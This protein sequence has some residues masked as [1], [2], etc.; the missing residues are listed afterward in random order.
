MAEIIY[1]SGLKSGVIGFKAVNSIVRPANTTAYAV[2]DLINDTAATT[3]LQFD[4]GTENANATLEINHVTL[5]SDYISAA[6]KL[7]AAL[8][9]FNASTIN[10]AGAVSQVTD[11]AAFNPSWAQIIAKMEGMVESMADVGTLGTSAYTIADESTTIVKL[12]SNGKIWVAITANNAYT[13]ASG[14]NMRLTIKGY[15]LG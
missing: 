15:I 2:G 12:D 1:R 5:M 3:L 9:F 8:W 11:N 10:S 4:F 7:D 13:P 14:E 6:T